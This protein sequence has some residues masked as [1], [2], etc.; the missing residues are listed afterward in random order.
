MYRGEGEGVGG[1]QC[2][3]WT[4][5]AD[6]AFKNL[7]WP[8]LENTSADGESNGILKSLIVKGV[9]AW[10]PEGDKVVPEYSAHYNMK[11]PNFPFFKSLIISSHVY[12][13]SVRMINSHTKS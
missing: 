7:P 4:I 13:A 2:V 6:N 1:K 3:F 9:S 5:A 11:S 12:P 8:L 10:G